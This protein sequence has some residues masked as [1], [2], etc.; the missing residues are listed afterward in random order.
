MSS[1][2]HYKGKESQSLDTSFKDLFNPDEYS[3]SGCAARALFE[4]LINPYPLNTFFEYVKKIN[5]RFF[6]ILPTFNAV[7]SGKRNLS[8]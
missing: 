6:I 7:R 3:D 4:L 2:S 8:C 5:F 1:K